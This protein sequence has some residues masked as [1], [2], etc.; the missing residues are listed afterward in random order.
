[1]KETVDVFI[2]VM[3]DAK[4]KMDNVFTSEISGVTLNGQV[5]LQKKI[6]KHLKNKDKLMVN[7]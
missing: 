1:M 3:K 2:N 5:N 7:W 4:L 6:S